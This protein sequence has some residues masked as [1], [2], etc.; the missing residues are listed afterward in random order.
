MEI[1]TVILDWAGTTVDFGCFAPVDA[2]LTAFEAYGLS[3]TMAETRAPM[4]MQKRAHIAAMLSG[5]RLR[6]AFMTRYGRDWTDEDVDRLYAAFEPALMRVLADHADVMP[7]V[8]KTASLLRG[9]GIKIGSTTGYTAAMMET[10]IREA[11]AAGYQPDA[12]VCPDETGGVGR[13]YPY[14]LFRNLE[15]LG[16][17]NIRSVLKLGDTVADIE[18]GKNAGCV[19]VGAIRGSSIL[20]LNRAEH[21]A[22]AGAERTRRYDAARAEFYAAGADTVIDSIEQLPELIE[23]LKAEG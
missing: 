9:M 10:V 7:G 16:E 21:D 17:P 20:G 6:A 19:S 12:I 22:L 5:D 18:E 1:S 2:F 11:C 8:V 14:M 15:K 3:P 13:P 23:T 4:G